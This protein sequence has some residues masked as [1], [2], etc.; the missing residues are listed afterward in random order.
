MHEPSYIIE[1]AA[2][3]FGVSAKDMCTN[4]NIIN[5]ST[6][7]KTAYLLLNKY[8]ALESYRIAF[9]FAVTEGSV[10]SALSTSKNNIAICK[11]VKEIESKYLTQPSSL[12]L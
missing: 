6:S 9:I 12:A 11:A 10:R 8:C 5:V 4:K 1:L 3:H 7:R 2:R